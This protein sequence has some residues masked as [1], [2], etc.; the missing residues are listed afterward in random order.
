MK[1][2]RAVERLKKEKLVVTERGNHLLTAK[3][4]KA[5]KRAKYNRDAAGATYG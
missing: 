3:G 4:E 2:Q 5:A 1:V